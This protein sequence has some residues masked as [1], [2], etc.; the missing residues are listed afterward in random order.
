MRILTSTIWQRHT[1]RELIWIKA[2]SVWNNDIGN[3]H[4]GPKLPERNRASLDANQANAVRSV[5][6]FRSNENDGVGRILRASR[7]TRLLFLRAGGTASPE[8]FAVV[9]GLELTPVK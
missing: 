3:S 9:R 1:R 4:P 2:A 8:G 6:G 5:L 7:G